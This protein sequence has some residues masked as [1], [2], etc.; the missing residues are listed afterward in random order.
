MRRCLG[1]CLVGFILSVSAAA[2]EDIPPDAARRAAIGYVDSLAEAR[3]A[4]RSS[5]LAALN[6]MDDADRRQGFVKRRILDLI[7]GLPD[8]AGELNAAVKARY[9]GEG[10]SFETVIF[11]SLPGYRVTANVFVPKGRGPFPAVIISPGHAPA[12]K[13]GDY[14]TGANFARAGILAMTY[15]I[16]G[17]GER[18]QHFDPDLDISKLER[19]TG[20]HSLMAYQTMLLGGAVA[21][22][23]IND[24]MRGVDYLSGRPDVDAERIGAFGCS[25]G[26]TMTAF[27]TALDPRIKAAASAGFVTTMHHLLE[28]VG[29]QEGEQSIPGFTAAG[30]DLPDWVELAAPRPYAIVST[31]E[32]MFPFAGARAAYEEAKG[33]WNLYGAADRIH[34]ITGP[35]RHCALQP[36]MPEILGFFATNLKTNGAVPQ[37]AFSRPARPEDVWATPSGQL[38]TSLGSETMQSLLQRRAENTAD[39]P[40]SVTNR[41]A[42]T[43][44]QMRLRRDVRAVTKAA[45]APGDPVPS[46]RIT[47]TDDDGAVRFERITFTPK[48]GPAFSGVLATPKAVRGRMIHLARFPPAQATASDGRVADLARA[49]WQ[50]LALEPIGGSGEEIKAKVLGDYTLFALRAMLVDRTVIGLRVDQAVAAANWLAGRDGR[51]LPLAIYGVGTLGPVA[52]HAA[53]LDERFSRVIVQDAQLRYRMS[54]DGPISRDLPEIAMPVVLTKYDQPDLMAAL[55]P[56]RIDVIGPRDQTGRPLRQAAFENAIAA[57]RAGDAAL[58]LSGRIVWWPYMPDVLPAD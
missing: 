38:S 58:H 47:A 21:R 49:G 23:F 48:A 39:K 9:P 36:I 15:D 2:L 31:T 27:L 26:G 17:E 19:P 6:D 13:A 40:V 33:F 35:G 50:V 54:V 52:L 30:L 57:V 7:G 10:F 12:G 43:A 51:E 18:W 44:L 28:S 8:G 25:G 3:L 41:K 37:I 29:P 56:R 34:W 16:V 32:D 55:A 5:A 11:D 53:V 20:E 1:I 46:A 4:E 45:A 14:A 24:A 22:Y 42:L